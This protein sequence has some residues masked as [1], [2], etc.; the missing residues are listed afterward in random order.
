MAIYSGI[1]IDQKEAIIVFLDNEKEKVI[2]VN[3][4]VDVGNVKGGAGNST[5]YAMQDAVSE[6]K[7][8]EKKKHQMHEFFQNIIEKIGDSDEFFILGPA[9]AKYGL[10]KEINKNPILKR[11]LIMVQTVDSM[12]KNQVIARVKAFFRATDAI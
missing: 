3:S 9:E 10:Q 2:N 1:W 11:K 6:S 7:F 8:M 12:T 5:P 4:H